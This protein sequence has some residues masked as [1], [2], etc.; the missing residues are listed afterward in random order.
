MI[1]EGQERLKDV[2]MPAYYRRY[3]H[4][5]LANVQKYYEHAARARRK[6]IDVTVVVEPK[7]AFDLADRVA[8]M[9]NIDIA[10]RL[11]ALLGTTTKEKAAL[12]IAEEIAKG[13]Y[14]TGDLRTRLDNAVRV[15]LAVV[16]EGVTVAPLQGISDVT[17]KN[18][19]DGSEY[20]YLLQGP[21][22][23]PAAPKRHLPC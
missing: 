19:A 4:E 20:L 13:E 5:I 12:K 10:E 16:T 7:I 2:R 6:G 21:S 9:H 17:I 1:S 11:R 23:R 15:S 18:N 14:G 8:K 22:G 3:Q